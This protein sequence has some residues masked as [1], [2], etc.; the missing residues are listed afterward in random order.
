VNT[1]T[2]TFFLVECVPHLFEVLNGVR[3]S[4]PV[5]IDMIG[6]ISED[7]DERIRDEKEISPHI[8]FRE[9]TEYSISFVILGASSR[10][11]ELLESLESDFTGHRSV[12]DETPRSLLQ[13]EVFLGKGNELEISNFL[14]NTERERDRTMR[15]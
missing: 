14:F 5:T 15:V 7:L 9:Q 2:N 1:P 13:E 4:R 8:V 12:E 11:I 10:Q 6:A 3:R